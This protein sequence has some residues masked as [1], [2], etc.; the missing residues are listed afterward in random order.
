MSIT[1]ERLECT[2][3]ELELH[4]EAVRKMAYRRWRAAGC[5]EYAELDFWL[6]AEREWIERSY[7]PHRLVDG[8]RSQPK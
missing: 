1:L 6:D 8:V 7:V 4:K 3:E 5:P 2:P